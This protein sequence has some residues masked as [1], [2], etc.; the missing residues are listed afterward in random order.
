ML[1]QMLC[2]TIMLVSRRGTS[3]SGCRV[4]WRPDPSYIY[5]HGA[6]RRSTPAWFWLW[7]CQQQREV[8]QG[9]RRYSNS[10][11]SWVPIPGHKGLEGSDAEN[12]S[13][14]DWKPC[15]WRNPMCAAQSHYSFLE[16]YRAGSLEVRGIVYV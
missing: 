12:I 13:L 2:L 1:R 8:L 16:H 4:R 3:T 7:T 6:K 10:S 9:W 5:L 11:K 14:V 15:A